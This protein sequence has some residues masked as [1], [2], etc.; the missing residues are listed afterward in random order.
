MKKLRYVFTLSLLCTASWAGI[1]AHTDYVDGQVIT[2]ALQNSNE[3]TLYNEFNG[4]IDSNNIKA[5]G[6][7]NAN[8]TAGTITGDKI[9]QSATIVIS[10]FTSNYIVASTAAIPNMVGTVNASS[11]PVGNIG[12]VMM[13]AT[14]QSLGNSPKDITSIDLIAGDWDVSGCASVNSGTATSLIL[15]VSLSTDSFNGTTQGYDYVNVGAPT[16]TFISACIPK[17]IVNI[18]STTRVHLVAQ[19]NTTLTLFGS[20]TARR[21]R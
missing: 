10:S 20:L 7:L 18:T 4:N 14:S 12:E 16:S 8:I 6:I 17:K 13:A 2:A 19:L 3:N 9:N 11:A 1:V 15:A 5:G 21:V